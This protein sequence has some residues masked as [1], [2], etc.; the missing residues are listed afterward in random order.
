MGWHDTSATQYTDTRGNNV[1]AQEDTDANNSPAVA[2]PMAA[3]N[4]TSI[5]PSTL[6]RNNRP[7]TEDFAITNLFYWNNIIHDVL[8]HHV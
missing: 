6:A 3:L 5:S 1:F 7:S 2:D 4:L 8:W